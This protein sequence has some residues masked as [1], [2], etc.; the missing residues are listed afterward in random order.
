VQA[1]FDEASE[2]F[3]EKLTRLEYAVPRGLGMAIAEHV[4]VGRGGRRFATALD[5]GC[6][7]GR[8]GSYLRP[9]VSVALIGTD[10]SPKMLAIAAELRRAAPSPASSPASEARGD[11]LY[12]RL[13]AQDVLQASREDLLPNL[14]PAPGASAGVE[15]VAAAD[16]LIYFG[17]LAPLFAATSALS[18][19]SS[20]LAVSA[21]LVHAQQAPQGWLLLRS[22]RF[23]HT[24]EYVVEMAAR[25]G[26]Y[27][28]VQYAGNIIPRL[29]LLVTV[30]AVY[31]KAKQVPTKDIMK[32][33]VE[34]CRGVQHPLRGLFLRKATSTSGFTICLASLSSMPPTHRRVTCSPLCPVSSMLM[35]ACNPM[36]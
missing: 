34:M 18:A 10:L 36:L 17:N 13:V 2:T 15:L 20:V 24:K 30:G 3:D 1:L 4:R 29:Y 7:T 23:A 35:G 14:L 32:D 5:A 21:E 11:S 8:L 33:L 31:I 12:D 9:L 26:G 6:G 27:E 22:G 28:L 25:A 16:V 19:A